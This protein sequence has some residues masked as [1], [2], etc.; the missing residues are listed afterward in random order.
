[1]YLLEIFML[2]LSA[3]AEKSFFSLITMCMNVQSARKV[4]RI[5]DRH[6]LQYLGPDN[7]TNM[8]GMKSN[9]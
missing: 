9:E 6:N 5:I 1:M 2:P 8:A 7:T 4:F 3:V